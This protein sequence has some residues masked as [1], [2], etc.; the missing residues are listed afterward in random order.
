MLL[1]TRFQFFESWLAQ[2]ATKF[3]FYFHSYTAQVW[4]RLTISSR[5]LG[6]DLELIGW[7]DLPV[8][9]YERGSYTRDP[10]SRVFR[11][12]A[13]AFM[14]DCMLRARSH[15]KFIANFDLDDFPIA[16]NG[17][18]PEVLNQINDENVNI[19]EIIVDWRLTR[20]KIHWDSLQTPSDIRFMLSASRLLA[21]NSIR[22]DYLIS[23]KMFTRPE[24]VRI[25]FLTSVIVKNIKQRSRRL[26]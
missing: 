14:H 26:E 16:G 24:R 2:G 12:A 3:Y 7:S 1:Y 9:E 15:V 11:H 23:K 6:R 18:L 10:N 13:T 4:Q 22:Y 8:R 21:D 20:Q 19:A 25:F 5:K 17:S